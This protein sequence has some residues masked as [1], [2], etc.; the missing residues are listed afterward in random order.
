MREKLTQIQGVADRTRLH[1][2]RL[3]DKMG[4]VG[5][6]GK[7]AI[8]E[9]SNLL[10]G[11]GGGITQYLV[12]P[13]TA[14]AAAAAALA[15]HSTKMAIDFEEGMSKVNATA[16]L[17]KAELDKLR[18]RL[19]DIGREGAGGN[20]AR[21]PD[22][23]EKINSQVNNVDASMAILE[24]SVKGA[25]ATKADLDT[26]ASAMAQSLS[27]IGTENATADEVMNTLLKA[28]ELG[29]GE[30]N[31]FATYL[32]GLIAAGKNLGVAYEDVAGQFA[33]MT[34]KGQDAAS[35]S[36][37]IQNAYSVLGRGQVQKGLA[38]IGVNVFDEDGTMRSFDVIFGELQARTSTLNAEQKSQLFESMGLVDMQAKQAFSIL[39]NDSAKLK[40]IMDGVK[41][42]AGTLDSTMNATTSPATMLANM[43]DKF[44]ALLLDV[45]YA[46]LPFIM[47][48]FQWVS[49]L[50]LAI[51]AKMKQWTFLGDLIRGQFWITKTVLGFIWDLLQA[52][53]DLIGWIYD[54]TL[55]PLVDGFMKIYETIKRLL[56]LDGST[57][58]IDS[59]NRITTTPAPGAPQVPN[60]AELPGMTGGELAKVLGGGGGADS[61]KVNGIHG[62]GTQTR[63]V[64]VTIQKLQDAI[65]IHS[66]GVKEGAE[67]LRRIIQEELLRAISGAELAL[68]DG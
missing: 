18:E 23:F 54:N 2:E 5:A 35:A 46:I 49:D 62:G 16:K 10:P 13:Y 11:I 50:V 66:A 17:P 53:G 37:L 34:A 36:M 58:Q 24:T 22:A 32:P 9:I 43:A 67:D 7:A 38:N 30:M 26:V 41:D 60:T 65:H 19:I 57:I 27:A 59:N 15:I 47:E 1:M 29:A 68:G 64:T 28:K 40:T 48:T 12:N 20:L 8:G 14:A 42:S 33:Y 4:S 25:V 6:P 63:N 51:V 44:N 45:G 39:M 21:L 56:G 52:V 3:A 61:K 55:K 31:D